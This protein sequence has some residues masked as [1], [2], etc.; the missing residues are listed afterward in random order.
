[1]EEQKKYIAD[2]AET[3]LR[4][5]GLLKLK[6]AGWLRTPFFSARPLGW[7]LAEPPTRREVL[8]T[9]RG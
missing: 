3:S 8:T 1:M 5:S 7:D 4:G 2:Y 6:A 9:S